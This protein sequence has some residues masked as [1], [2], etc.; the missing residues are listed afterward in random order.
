MR[1]YQDSLSSQKYTFPSRIYHIKFNWLNF[2]Q[3]VSYVSDPGHALIQR[4][5]PELERNTPRTL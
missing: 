2:N 1:V 4:D 5:D 3:L